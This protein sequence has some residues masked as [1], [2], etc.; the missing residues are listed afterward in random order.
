[1][2]KCFETKK[3]LV[4]KKDHIQQLTKKIKIFLLST[5]KN[6]TYHKL[7][8]PLMKSN[9]QYKWRRRV[10]IITWVYKHFRLG[11]GRAPHSK[12]PRKTFPS[13]PSIF[14]FSLS[15]IFASGITCCSCALHNVPRLFLL[16]QTAER[17]RTF[18]WRR[19]HVVLWCMDFQVKEC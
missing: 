9:K 11:Q 15:F 16:C 1:M 6:V 14:L 8:L 4:K 2:D 7:R 17:H 10:W 19:K 12:I 13:F 18:W 3:L 5:T